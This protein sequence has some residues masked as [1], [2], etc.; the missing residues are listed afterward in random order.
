MKRKGTKFHTTDK[1]SSELD[2]CKPI[3]IEEP[4]SPK[5]I[6]KAI[7]EGP[8]VAFAAGK[9]LIYFSLTSDTLA[10]C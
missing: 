1:Q 9:T 5:D 2:K 7:T 6:Q 3:K 10:F 4:L 8:I